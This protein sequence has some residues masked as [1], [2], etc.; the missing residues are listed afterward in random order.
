MQQSKRQFEGETMMITPARRMLME[1]LAGHI[2]LLQ[3][4]HPKKARTAVAK[5][6]KKCITLHLRQAR[7]MAA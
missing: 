4:N 2:A 1:T 6:A 5:E 3:Q 7:R